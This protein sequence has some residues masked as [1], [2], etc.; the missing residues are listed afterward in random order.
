MFQTDSLEATILC[1]QIFT[2]SNTLPIVS[3][4]INWDQNS[5]G[6]SINRI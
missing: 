2:K 1:Q 4:V 5:G 3:Q 6:I